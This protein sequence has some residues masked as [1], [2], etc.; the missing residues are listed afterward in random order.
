MAGATGAVVATYNRAD[1]RIY[2]LDCVN[3]TDP[4][5]AKIQSLIEEWVEK[6]VHK[7]YVLKLTHTRRLT[8]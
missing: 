7:N 6:Y 2:V 4:S 8:P 3:M 1:G 5:P